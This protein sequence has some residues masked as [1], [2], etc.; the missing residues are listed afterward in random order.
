M[1]NRFISI[2]LALALS[3]SFVATAGASTVSDGI[4]PNLSEVYDDRPENSEFVPPDCDSVLSLKVNSSESAD[5]APDSSITSTDTDYQ[6]SNEIDSGAGESAETE[7]ADDPVRYPINIDENG[8]AEIE[9]E[10]PITSI[11]PSELDIGE[12]MGEESDDSIDVNPEE[13]ISPNS[14]VSDYPMTAYKLLWVSGTITNDRGEQF[15]YKEDIV[16]TDGN[17]QDFNPDT[18]HWTREFLNTENIT[19]AIY[20]AGFGYYKETLQTAIHEQGN[21]FQWTNNP[22]TTLSVDADGAATSMRW[23]YVLY[24]IDPALTELTVSFVAARRDDTAEWRRTLTINFAGDRGDPPTTPTLYF[25]RDYPEQYFLTG[26]DE[27]MEYRV[28]TSRTWKPCTGN[29]MAFS[30]KLFGYDLH[31]RYRAVNGGLES[32][33]LILSIPKRPEAPTASI[34]WVDESFKNLTTDMEFSVGDQEYTPVTDE[35]IAGGIT[36]FLDNVTGPDY[37]PLNIRYALTD[38]QPVSEVKTIKLYPRADMPDETSLQ[39]N[40]NTYV[41]TGVTSSMQ[42]KGP[43]DTAWKAISGTSVNLSNYAK[44]GETVEIQVRTKSSTGKSYS[45]YVSVYLDPPAA[46]PSTLALD[47]YNE[48][49]TGF[50]SGVTYQYKIGSGTWKSLAPK[51]LEYS[52]A[53]LITTKDQELSIRAAG[54]ATSQMSGAWTVTLPARIAAPACAFIY[55]DSANIGSAVLTGLETG[56]EYQLKGETSWIPS[57]GQNIV[58]FLPSANK[59]YYVRVAPTGSSFASTKKTLTLYA[60]GTA[61]TSSLNITTENITISKTAEYRI[62]NGAYTT[63]PSGTTTL[64]ATDYIDQLSGG[65]TCTI[66]VRFAATETKPASK[67][68]TI[69]LVARRDGPTTVQYDATTQKISGATTS[70]Q[71]RVVGTTSW[72][73]I[74]S[75]SFSVASL[76]NGQTN[77]VL[78]FRYKPA[79]SLVGSRS[80]FVNCF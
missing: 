32:Q 24:D 23:E 14:S 64:S 65:E 15:T 49:I 6:I 47:Y 73:T 30:S 66:T 75:K 11:D 8:H 79:N 77:V 2:V 71:Y 74:T 68:K 58:M 22:G 55:N 59:T 28:D 56:M 57:S 61:P 70:M 40:P 37:V 46:A 72:K 43:E 25:D 35:I 42:Y 52:I 48:K 53:S 17:K 41:L 67:E 29:T 1:N 33:Y 20:Q 76:I 51:N 63:L 36:P 9:I 38:S 3:L 10:L 19:I 16:E 7:Q 13:S 45:K 4:S 50:Q 80:T 5:A 44:N 12:T 78:E 39:V 27:T 54:T 60:P 26:V 21:I 34:N 62:D 31:I 18:K 69:K